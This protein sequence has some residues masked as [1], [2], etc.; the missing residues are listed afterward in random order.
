MKTGEVVLYND[1]GVCSFGLACLHRLVSKFITVRS[2]DA[3]SV[4]S[5]AAFKDCALFVIGGGA[6]LPYCRKLGTEGAHAIRAFV[7]GG[8]IYLGICS[9]S[10]F[11]STN[12]EF[13]KDGPNAICGPRD[14]SLFD[15]TAS[16]PL[17]DI[18][19]AYDTTLKSAAIT[20]IRLADGSRSHSLY[21]GGPFFRIADRSRT[22][23]LAH[24]ESP[25]RRPAIVA[26]LLG[27]GQAILSGVHLEASPS[28]L[29][30][31]PDLSADER[32]RANALAATLTRTGA[33][34]QENLRL[35]LCQAGMPFR[36]GKIRH[37]LVSSL[38]P[39]A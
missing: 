7:R 25:E 28:D 30:L 23:I 37:G 15:G 3:D 36:A 2:A 19:A 13:D 32:E 14:L 4:R 21:H 17:T 11:A 9:G 10:Y 31:C 34:P 27:K 12:G 39:A 38:Q 20:P 1:D 8:G 33:N 5:G 29:R 16:G 26:T 35:I 22:N 18:A 24:Y 6:D